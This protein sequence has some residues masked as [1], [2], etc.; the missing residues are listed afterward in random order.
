MLGLVVRLLLFG[1]Y[2]SGYINGMCC[3]VCQIDLIIFAHTCRARLSSCQHLII[4]ALES[5]SHIQ[6]QLRRQRW[7]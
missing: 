2:M 7:Q 3:S 1:Y 4:I 6:S 5:H